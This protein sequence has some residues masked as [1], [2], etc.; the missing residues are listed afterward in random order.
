MAVFNNSTTVTIPPFG[1]V[2]FDGDVV[3]ADSEDFIG[4]NKVKAP[5]VDNGTVA[6]NGPAPIL[7]KSAGTAFFLSRGVVA[8]DQSDGVPDPTNPTETWG[9]A[10]GSFLVRKGNTGFKA[11]RA[12][13]SGRFEYM[14]TGGGATSDSSLLL[15]KCLSETPAGGAGVEVECYDGI[16]KAATTTDL[17]SA[18]ADGERVWLT[19]VGI[20]GSVRP[21]LNRYYLV[22]RVNAGTVT[23]SGDTRKRVIGQERTIQRQTLLADFDCDPNTGEPIKYFVCIEGPF[24]VT[25]GACSSSSSSGA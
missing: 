23:I 16:I 19:P 9:P 4:L 20:S 12:D 6:V 7:P 25:A 11:T 15:V 5:T 18:F 10:A 8:Y 24:T 3:A 2:E 22:M 21:K 17:A 14:R 1:V 13:R